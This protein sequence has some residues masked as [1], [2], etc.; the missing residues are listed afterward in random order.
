MGVTFRSGG[1][2]RFVR[3][4]GR[5]IKDGEAA[6]IW[7]QQG[8]Q[9]QII[10]PRRVRLW[11]S[12][13]RFLTRYKAESHQYI[14]VKHRD[15]RREHIRG[16]AVLFGNPAYHDEVSVKDAILLKSDSEFIVV[17]VHNHNQPYCAKKKTLSGDD[18]SMNTLNTPTSRCSIS[19]NDTGTRRVIIQGPTL[20][21]PS[22]N[23][24]VHTFSWCQ[25]GL[26][27]RPST[28]EK[29]EFSVFN[30]ASSHSLAPSSAIKLSFEL[31]STHS[32]EA[33]LDVQFRFNFTSVGLS[34]ASAVESHEKEPTMSIIESLLRF[35]DPIMKMYKAI[36]AD[37]VSIGM[38]IPL[39][40]DIRGGNCAKVDR[41]IG[42]KSAYK[43]LN[44]V[45]REC[46][47]EITSL[48]VVNRRLNDD[49]VDL[50]R[51]ER[52]LSS[53]IQS[54]ITETEQRKK[55]IALEQETKRKAIEDE[56]ELK[57]M[58]L[59]SDDQLDKEMHKMKIA[60]LERS[61]ELRMLQVRASQEQER[62][63]NENALSLMQDMKNM[64]VD[65]TRFLVSSNKPGVLKTV[66]DATDKLGHLG[67]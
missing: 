6:A 40:D 20:F 3:I 45:A 9:T 13:I 65:L 27:G 44:K 50:I 52:A 67:V 63:K 41:V 47:I 23:E 38:S 15:G 53:K 54:E 19:E 43:E 61:L 51:N 7:N 37:A 2:I 39:D 30:G 33:D 11:F 60:S 17:Y 5:T 66:Q 57:R 49:L 4:G 1:Y 16:P 58:Q 14:I 31:P 10:G 28:N 22:P 48:T 35:E 42:D 29:N 21:V 24:E 25:F 55:V 32:I 36:Q 34:G 18:D 8:K 64:G 12:T 26:N 59:T 46:G 62:A 56:V